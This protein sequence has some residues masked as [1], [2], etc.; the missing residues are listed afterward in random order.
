MMPILTVFTAE[1]VAYKNLLTYLEPP[2]TARHHNPYREWI[3]AQIRADVW[4][5]VSPGDTRRAA[6]LAWQDARLS[7]TGN[8]IYGEVY[9]AAMIATA[10]VTDD[11]KQVVDAGL[12]AIPLDSRLAEAVRFACSL[13][14]RQ[15]SW[16]AAV[17]ELYDQIW[18][19]PLGAY[20]QQR[21]PAHCSPTFWGVVTSTKTI[22]YAV[23]GGWDTDCNGASA[24]AIIGTMLG[25]G[26]VP[27]AWWGPLNNRVRT[28]LKG[29][30]QR[31][32]RRVGCPHRERWFQTGTAPS[33][34]AEG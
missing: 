27:E 23:M 6:E 15:D 22:T 13:P 19:L 11:I 4:G 3:G 9:V 18:A 32:D 25:R 2:E 12:K 17:D 30:R 33:R 31:C 1:R 14:E 28:S 16:E 26:G 8:G 34:P 10:F 24:G 29:L 7:H 5:W 20:D 21:C